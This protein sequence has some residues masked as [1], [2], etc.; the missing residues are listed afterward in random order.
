[1]FQRVYII[2]IVWPIRDLKNVVSIVKTCIPVW[3][4]CADYASSCIFV[5]RGRRAFLLHEAV[6]CLPAILDPER[7]MLRWQWNR[8]FNLMTIFRGMTDYH[9]LTA[10]RYG[11][12]RE[13][14]NTCADG[15]VDVGHQKLTNPLRYNITPETLQKQQIT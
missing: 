10:D 4:G 12:K 8:C 5:C 13:N 3:F 14:A 1:M 11:M 15:L 7:K 6:D 2:A 9:R